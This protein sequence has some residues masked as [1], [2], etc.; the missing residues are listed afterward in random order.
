ME[1]QYV[2]HILCVCVCVFVALG[3]QRACAC[4]VFPSVACPDLQCFFP[5][6]LLIGTIF[7][8]KKKFNWT[9][10]GC[11]LFCTTFVCN[12]FILGRNKQDM[13][14]KAYWSSCKVLVILVRFKW[15]L[16]FLNGFSKNIQISNCMKILSVGAELFRGDGRT[17]GWRD[18]TKLTVA[19]RN[20]ATYTYEFV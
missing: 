15:N 13:N 4:A 8:E 7:F 3:A 10:H 6:Y 5:R 9:R 19:F 17:D 18:I 12:I 11:F 20:F 2:L 1:K 14:K 16:N